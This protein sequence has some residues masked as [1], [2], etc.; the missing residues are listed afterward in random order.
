MEEKRKQR[1]MDKIVR[2]RIATFLNEY[3]Y[4]DEKSEKTLEDDEIIG[5]VIGMLIKNRIFTPEGLRKEI[6]KKCNV[7]LPLEY[8]K[9]AARR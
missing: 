5:E 1:I 2:E 3:V 9:Y 4:I 6:L 7:L 8:I